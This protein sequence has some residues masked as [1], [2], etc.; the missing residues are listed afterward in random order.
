MDLGQVVSRLLGRLETGQVGVHHRAVAFDGE[1]QRHVHRNAFGDNGGDRRQPGKGGGDLDQQVGPV[2]DLPQL[3]G[4]QDGL[5]GVVRQPRVDLDRHPAVDAAGRLVLLGQHVARVAHVVGG[6]R[7]DGGVHIG[8]A[9]RQ[10]LD[11]SS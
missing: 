2:D 11:L 10:L 3:D 8:P 7:A 4:L 5:V 6:D 1:D 9:L